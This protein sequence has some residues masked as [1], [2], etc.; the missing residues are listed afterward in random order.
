MEMFTYP[1]AA[2][3]LAAGLVTAAAPRLIPELHL[4][5]Y[6]GAGLG[7]ADYAGAFCAGLFG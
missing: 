5:A 2:V 1:L 6:F 4:P 3:I 7:T